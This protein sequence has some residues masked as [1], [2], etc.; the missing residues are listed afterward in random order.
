MKPFYINEAHERFFDYSENIELYKANAYRVWGLSE[1]DYFKTFHRDNNKSYINFNFIK[2]Y[3]EKMTDLILSKGIYIETENQQLNQWL[4]DWIEENNYIKLQSKKVQFGMVLGDSPV[5]ISTRTN[6]RADVEV[7]ADY[8]NPDK[9]YIIS[10]E[11]NINIVKGQA[12]C[13][14]YTINKK[15]YHL[16]EEHYT[17]RIIYK[18]FTE[19]GRKW[20]QVNIEDYEIIQN[21][22]E[23]MEYTVD[24]LDYIVATDTFYSTIINYQNETAFDSVYGDSDFDLGLKSIMYNINDTITGIH[25]TNAMTRDP[26][27][28]VPAGTIKGILDARKQQRVKKTDGS[29]ITT[30]P[31]KRFTDDIDT[32]INTNNNEQIDML[33][34]R[35]YLSEL[36]YKS[37]AIEKSIDGQSL[38]VVEH[39]PQ[40]QNSFDEL[41]KLQTMLYQV[42]SV[43]PILIDPEYQVGRLSGT[44]IR[45]LAIATLKKASRKTKELIKSIQQELYTIQELA[46]NANLDIP[47]TQAIMPTIEINDGLGSDPSDDIIWLEKAIKLGLIGEVDAI[48]T[49]RDLSST[50]AEKKLKE[51]ESQKEKTPTEKEF[52]N[53]VNTQELI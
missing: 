42:S 25:A 13:H 24:G 53:N 10:D 19:I 33:F 18:F 31:Y 46:I 48:A 16:V 44:A 4:N 30:N 22:F 43:S 27:Y 26:L 29:I 17:G 21:S 45:N 15:I 40:M 41:K 35:E 14:D 49:L 28:S 9:W 5:K 23:G 8:I 34:A 7:K 47:V 6:D 36:L 39:N 50:E 1:K 11:R 2:L 37:R 38:E 51:I 12:I 20:E 3:T 32:A 52:D